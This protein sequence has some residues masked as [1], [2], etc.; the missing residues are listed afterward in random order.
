MPEEN[1][2]ALLDAGIHKIFTP[3]RYG[4]YK[5]TGAHKLMLLEVGKGC[6]DIMDV[7]CSDVTHME[8]WPFSC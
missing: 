6:I 7:I 3:K 4:G 2:Q 1:M 8:L 5:W